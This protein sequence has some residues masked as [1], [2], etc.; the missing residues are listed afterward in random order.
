MILV[1]IWC[2][3]F[4]D[5][6][7]VKKNYQYLNKINF[8]IYSIFNASNKTISFLTHI[9]VTFKIFWNSTVFHFFSY[10]LNFFCVIIYNLW[11]L[12]IVVFFFKIWLLT[13]MVFDSFPV[14]FFV[15][16]SFG[17]G[18]WVFPQSSSLCCHFSKHWTAVQKFTF[19]P[20]HINWIFL[21]ILRD[22][23]P[24]FSFLFCF[25]VYM[26]FYFNVFS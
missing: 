26:N 6:I 19:K 20:K 25:L 14:L 10:Y 18:W 17:K 12:W 8:T 11:N 9:V 23:S 2:H 16:I 22:C 21:L 15:T 5:Y 1:Q 13:Y 24:N 4:Q 7:F 3:C